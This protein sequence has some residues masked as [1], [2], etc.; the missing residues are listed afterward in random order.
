MSY[1]QY[2]EQVCVTYDIFWRL[3][4]ANQHGIGGLNWFVHK[5]AE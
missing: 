2:G 3:V 4:T 5:R 1:L